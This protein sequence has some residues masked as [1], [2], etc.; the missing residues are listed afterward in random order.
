[1]V[2]LVG[3]GIGLSCVDY[4]FDMGTG[5]GDLVGGQLAVCTDCCA[6]DGSGLRLAASKGVGSDRLFQKRT[7]VESAGFPCENGWLDLPVPWCLV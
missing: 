3:F 6:L 7:V 4:G 5:M 2:G 1:M